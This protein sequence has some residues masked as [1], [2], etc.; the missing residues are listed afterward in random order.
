MIMWHVKNRLGA[1]GKIKSLSTISHHQSSGAFLWEGNWA[2]KLLAAIG[3]TLKSDTSSPGE[4][5]RSAKSWLEINANLQ[6]SKTPK[7]ISEVS[8]RSVSEFQK[9]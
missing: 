7:S 5:A 1:L 2:S 6:S 8:Y 3:A 9:Q 4:C